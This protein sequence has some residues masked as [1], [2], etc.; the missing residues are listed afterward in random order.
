M[1]IIIITVFLLGSIMYFSGLGC[2]ILKWTGIPCFGCG[3]TRA[4]IS[5]VHLDFAMAWQYHPMVFLMPFCIVALLMAKKMPRWLIKVILIGV[6]ALFVIIYFVRLL[7]P[8]NPVVQW[9]VKNGELYKIV[10][11]LLQR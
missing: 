4:V 2:P 6:V 1:L 11:R 8:E 9:N 3:M 7:S 10:N 5:L